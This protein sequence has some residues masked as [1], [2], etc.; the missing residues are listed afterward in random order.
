MKLLGIDELVQN[1]FGLWI[2][3]L[4]DGIL[5]SNPT[6]TF[7][8]H[9]EAFSLLLKDFL[10]DGRIKFCPPTELWRDGYDVWDADVATILQYLRSRWPEAAKSEND[11]ILTDYFY[12]IP[13]ILWVAP[14]GTLHGS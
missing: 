8:E 6:L 4:F 10:E 7:D 13:A 5:V 11:L 3:A 12:E 2:T 14:D 9:R 1:V